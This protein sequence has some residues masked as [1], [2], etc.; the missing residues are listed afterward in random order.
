M[1]GMCKSLIHPCNVRD[2][3]WL[4]P[5]NLYLT[6]LACDLTLVLLTDIICSSS[7]L[8]SFFNQEAIVLRRCE[9]RRFVRHSPESGRT[10]VNRRYLAVKQILKHIKV[11]DDFRLNIISEI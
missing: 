1:E 5:E 8:H 3:Y 4:A 11:G 6:A 2:T 9:R 7:S 10:R